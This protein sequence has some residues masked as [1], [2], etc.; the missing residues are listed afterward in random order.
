MPTSGTFGSP[1]GG[2]RLRSFSGR[3]AKGFGVGWVGVEQIS[4]L[5]D[6]CE[7]AAVDGLREAMIATG[8]EAIAWAKDNAPWQDQTGQARGTDLPP[9]DE[10]SLH[11]AVAPEGPY[12]FSLHLAHG[13]DYGVYLEA[14]PDTAILAATAVQAMEMFTSHAEASMKAALGGEAR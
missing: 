9:E 14:N 7:T 10:S 12:K 1:P 4:D 5:F 11:Y 3:F 8:Q 2:T 13:V 6:R